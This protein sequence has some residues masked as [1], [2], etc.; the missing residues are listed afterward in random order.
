LGIPVIYVVWVAYQIYAKKLLPPTGKRRELTIYFFRITFIFIFFWIPMLLVYFIFRG[1]PPWA[2][3]GFAVFT[4]SAGG[5]SAV[6]STYKPDI[7]RATRNF[8]RC[9]WLRRTPPEEDGS[10]N[11]YGFSGGRGSSRLSGLNRD[12]LNRNTSSMASTDL[13]DV[14]EEEDEDQEDQDQDLTMGERD[15]EQS[16]HVLAE[17]ASK[18]SLPEASTDAPTSNCTG[19]DNNDDFALPPSDEEER[20][21]VHIDSAGQ[22]NER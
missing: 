22:I 11:F 2:M 13:Y 20:R 3:F 21:S 17:E 8:L 15:V 12:V 5:V 6:Y 14:K 7:G 1:L 16:V 4:H 18:R 9:K 19:N 10:T